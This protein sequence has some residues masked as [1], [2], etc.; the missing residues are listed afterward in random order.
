V[1]P[2]ARAR[3]GP[4]C[5]LAEICGDNPAD[6]GATHVDINVLPAVTRE[7][8][9]TGPRL[10]IVDDG[11]GMSAEQLHHA[12][13]HGFTTRKQGRYGMVCARR[14]SRLP[15]AACA[16]LRQPSAPARC[17]RPSRA[18]VSGPAS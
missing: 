13:S 14:A 1:A 10:R 15:L 7:H 3:A 4:L 17:P 2:D 6:A 12:V 5:A 16:P 8:F 18:A 9:D 11:C